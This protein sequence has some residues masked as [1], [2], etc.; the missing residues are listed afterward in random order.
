MR[1]NSIET[2]YRQSTR[3]N[4]NLDPGSAR[5]SRA[6]PVRLGLSAPRRKTLTTQVR[7]YNM[8]ALA[9]NPL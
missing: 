7:S 3:E 9:N 5:A 1:D 8:I 6:T 2:F 4:F